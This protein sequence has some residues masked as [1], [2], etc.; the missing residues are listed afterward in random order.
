MT[1]A[2]DHAPMLLHVE[3]EGQPYVDELVTLKP[4]P[5]TDCA[6]AVRLIFRRPALRPIIIGFDRTPLRWLTPAERERRIAERE[7]K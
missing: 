7:Q 4:L 1:P 5:E 3:R 6:K 2:H